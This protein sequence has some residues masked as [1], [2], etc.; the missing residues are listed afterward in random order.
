[1][2]LLMMGPQGSGKGTIGVMLS[3]ALG[4]P[5]IA[6]GELLRSMSKSD[7]RYIEAKT[8]M[9]E[10]KLAPFELLVDLILSRIN[11]DDCRR[12]YILDGWARSM[13]NINFFNPGFDKVILLKISKN[14]TLK[15]LSTRRTCSQCDAVFNIISKPSKVEGVCDNCGGTLVQRADDTEAAITERLAIYEKQTTPVI[16][17]FKKRGTLLEIDAEGTPDEI[18]KLIMEKLE[19]K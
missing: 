11:L 2:K 17:Y 16:E 3:N 7:P 9:N 15:R 13:E 14:T 5:L 1:M 19:V 8:L 10:G 4:L 18:Y 12:G 6:A